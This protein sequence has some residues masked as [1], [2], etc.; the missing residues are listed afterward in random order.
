MTTEAKK[1]EHWH[2]LLIYCVVADEH[3]HIKHIEKFQNL[4]FHILIFYPQPFHHSISL[5]TN[6][7]FSPLFTASIQEA[8]VSFYLHS[9]SHNQL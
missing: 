7:V 2:I 3:S 1:A 5:Q 8:K 6:H 4:H 9:Q